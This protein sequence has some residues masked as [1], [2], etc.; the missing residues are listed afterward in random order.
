MASN[1]PKGDD[2]KGIAALAVSLVLAWALYSAAHYILIVLLIFAL[3]AIVMLHSSDPEAIAARRA[4]KEAIDNPELQA[5]A[6]RGFQ[7]G[8]AFVKAAL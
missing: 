7:R 3:I 5:D 2:V 1:K 4:M 6:L 8:V